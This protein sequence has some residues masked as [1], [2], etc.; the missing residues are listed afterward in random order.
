[1]QTM[2]KR[3]HSRRDVLRLMGTG[4]AMIALAACTPP[5]APSAGQA[6]GGAA[7]SGQAFLNYWTGWSGFEFDELQKLVDKFNTE[8]KDKIFVN[9]TTV[10]GQYDKVLTAI[11]G[12]NPPDVVSAVWLHQLVSM[13]ARDGLKPLTDYASRDGIDGA[14]Y[15]PQFWEAWHWNNQL[16]GL[17]VTSNSNVIAYRSDLYKEVGL[18][19]DKPPQNVTELD[20]AAQKLEKVGKDGTIERV[21][22]LPSGLNW[23]GRVFGGAFYDDKNQKI[24]ANDPKLVAALD[25]M[26]SYRKR[27]GPDK[28]AAFTSGYGDYMST[29]NSF[30]VGK[31]SMTQVG[32]W[33]IEFQHRFAP[34]LDM[35]FMPAPPPEG[36]RENCT[37]FD[38][39]VFTIPNGVKNADSSWEF[40]K[41]L[42]ADE[43]MGDFCFNIHNV[44]PKVKPATADR[45]VSD[46][47]FKLAVD[48]L[49]GKNAF[50]PDKMPVNDTLYTKIG[51]AE[52]AVFQGQ[53]KAQEVLDRVTQEVQQELDK[54]MERMKK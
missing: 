22:L 30:F 46:K 33:F 16:W 18:D 24:T 23:W 53:T 11:A 28:V 29:Q 50:G 8:H 36:G 45:F 14:G 26:G 54:A 17:M 19:A 3:L 47:R 12:G 43:H 51:E 7:K 9:M 52:S 38:G 6:A 49:N 2:S 20:A 41:W 44:P 5:P 35:R 37:T 10:F 48:L 32:E 39:S 15:F 4:G 31:E 27:L 21:G 42:S 34:D 13:A 1:M 25:W 40:I